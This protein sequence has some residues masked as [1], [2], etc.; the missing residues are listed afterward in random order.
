MWWD[1][2]C[3]YC[4]LAYSNNVDGVIMRCPKNNCKKKKSVKKGSFF[5]MGHMSIRQQMKMMICFVADV[6]VS[7]AARLLHIRRPTVSQYYDNLRG[8]WLDYLKVHPITFEDGDEFEVDECLIKHVWAPRKRKH[9]VQ[10]IGGILERSTG[11]VVLYKINDRSR[12]SLIPP[13]LE[14]I[15]LGSW[16]YSDEWKSY[17]AIEKHP[18]VHLTVNHSKKEYSRHEEVGGRQV[19][20][21]INTL[22]GINRVIRKRFANKS[23][24]NMERVELVLAEIMYRKS[25]QDLFHPFKF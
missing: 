21:H 13:M 1:F 25:F 6:T 22:E 7:A 15:P 3:L 20:I 18:Y 2:V 4:V 17:Q 23:S 19:N 8:E 12:K 11:K 9:V 14:K 10:W 16:I 5:S 24:R